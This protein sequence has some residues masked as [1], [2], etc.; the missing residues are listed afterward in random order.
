MSDDKEK[1]TENSPVYLDANILFP[2]S[3]TLENPVFQILL[4][5]AKFWEFDLYLPELAYHE[6]I[7]KKRDDIEV[8]VNK[9]INSYKYLENNYE[10]TPI[11]IDKISGQD[12]FTKSIT[13][14]REYLSQ[15]NV[16]I[17]ESCSI[18][19]K[20]LIDMSL[21]NVRPF[22]EK[23]EKGFRDAVILFTVL[24]H[25]KSI[26]K[27][28]TFISNDRVFGHDDI[29]DIA[30]E[31]GVKISV[32][33]S[34]EEF[35]ESMESL[36]WKIVEMYKKDELKKLTEFLRTRT[37]Q[38]ADFIRDQGK[39]SI[40][41]LNMLFGLEAPDFTKLFMTIHEPPEPPA[42]PSVI[43]INNIELL[44]ITAPSLPVET[45]T[46]IVPVYFL[47]KLRFHV[48]VERTYLPT[49][50]Y[51]RKIGLHGVENSASGVTYRRELSEEAIE[52]DFP[53]YANLRM[54]GGVYKDLEL[55]MVGENRFPML[56]KE[57]FKKAT[58]KA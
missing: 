12:I 41:T 33:K 11:D 9:I 23:G 7:N 47:V 22:E 48:S 8:N 20:K 37:E 15:K 28:C 18:D 42:T 51:D 36:K 56:G 52:G 25:A 27:S 24:G 55:K 6:W 53:I 34:I 1:T 3:I 31:H 46:N 21:N 49:Y 45:E 29:L 58:A 5:I 14:L 4:E 30:K 54:D 40:M 43:K 44:D 35:K 17:I 2:F 13:V 10:L 39:F 19:T 16:N 50:L 38:I 57:L 26:N 32:Y